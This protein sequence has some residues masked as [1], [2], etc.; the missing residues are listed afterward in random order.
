MGRPRIDDQLQA[1]WLQA[2][3]PPPK[4]SIVEWCE[5]SIVLPPSSPE[6][7]PIK[8]VSYQRGLVEA[9]ADPEA[10]TLVFCLAAQTGKSLS[11]DSMALWAIA[12]APGPM[13]L[14]HPTEGKAL[15]YVRNRL[16]PLLAST[17][18]M[19]ELIGQGGRTGGGSSVRHKLF[20]AGSLSV[21][22][23]HNPDDLAARSIRY[24]WIDEVDRC[25]RSAG[26][27]GDPVALAIKRTRT[28]SNRKII[29]AS[30][31]TAKNSSRIFEWFLRG[32]QERFFVPCPEC[33]TFDYLRF[34][35]LKWTMGRPDTAAL[36]CSSCAH[37]ISERER[38]V[39]IDEGFW[40]GT[41]DAPEKSIR[42]FHATELISKFSTLESVAQQA[43][44][45]EASPEKK[46]VFH[47]VVLAETYDFGEEFQLDASE[48][49]LRAEHIPNPLPREITKICAG[50]DVQGDRV[51]ATLVGFA[52]ADNRIYVTQHSRLMGDTAG[53]PG[54][55][56]QLDALLATTFKTQDGRELP[57]S[58][59]AIDANFNT[60]YV[61]A[62]VSQQRRK[63]R[64]VIA[65]KGVG[66]FDK[67]TIRKGSL[68]RGLTQL[69]LVGVD[70]TKASIQKRL[71][72]QEVG[73]GFVH[74]AD[75]LEP[76]YFEG[77]AAE[78]LRTRYVRGY[79]KLEFHN[80]AKGSSAAGNEPLDC[81]CYAVAV[82][83]IA[84]AAT[85]K[86]PEA[87][88]RSLAEM[89]ARLNSS[90][91]ERQHHHV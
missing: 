21:G 80:T 48:L 16:D 13:L 62:F 42:S 20:P 30:T 57:I 76:T 34:E 71:S 74:L 38:L 60:S 47:N 29:L 90:S 54:P 50:V 82:A 24:L 43:E 27:E 59:A 91:N 17:A 73:P 33:G 63:Q 75:S 84:K 79:A 70:G 19:R 37:H 5:S 1:A 28:F 61:A 32:T 7:G 46:R 78:Q 23:S 67:P 44:E 31:P 6:P 88:K 69:Y 87:S 53:S 64:N 65:I 14:V 10:E 55:W 18:P 56:P 25:A 77:L 58:A 8:F 4:S 83:S 52:E 41:N 81:L 9:F 39:A 22:S 36:V 11:L 35:D 12:N 3:A 45:A 26:T 51:E 89:A 68:L 49:Q 15:D 40:Q 85:P 66:G 2:F 86:K 72:M